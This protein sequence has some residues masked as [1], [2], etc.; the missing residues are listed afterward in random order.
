MNEKP[1]DIVVIGGSAGSMQVIADILQSLPSKIELP[2]VI[3]IH[4]MK[5]VESELDRL[6]AMETSIKILEPDDKQPVL[7]NQVYLSPQNY[8]LLVEEDRTFSLDY[9]EQV[10]FSRPSIDVS[11][12][13]IASV[14]ANKTIGIL[15][16]GANR[17]GAEGL[18]D[19]FEAGGMAIVQ[20]PSTASYPAMP[21][22]GKELVPECKSCSPEEIIKLLNQNISNSP[23]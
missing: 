21:E 5:N 18:K 23:K 8:H 11:F 13:S 20:Q 15:L 9:S 2:I 14:Y 1:F 19:I 6:L 22:A 16:S 12:S 7:A 3:V 4:R 10:N 17:D